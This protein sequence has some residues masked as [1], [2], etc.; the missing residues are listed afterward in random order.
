V[1]ASC[2]TDELDLWAARSSSSGIA[3]RLILIRLKINY[4]FQDIPP[5][6]R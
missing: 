6:S 4:V 5:E 1:A 3:R 2:G